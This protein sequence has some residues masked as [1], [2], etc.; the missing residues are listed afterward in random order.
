MSDCELRKC[1]LEYA[2]EIL[3]IY[4][5]RGSHPKATPIELSD[6]IYQY[7]KEGTLKYHKAVWPI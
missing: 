1:C 5:S 2:I 7:I 4:H 6:I 3:S